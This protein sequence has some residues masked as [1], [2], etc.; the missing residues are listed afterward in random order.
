MTCHVKLLEFFF[1]IYGHTVLRVI[2]EF[3]LHYMVRVIVRVK[4]RVVVRVLDRIN[5]SENTKTES[6]D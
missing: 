5:L 2:S 1:V 6:L 4:M 3:H